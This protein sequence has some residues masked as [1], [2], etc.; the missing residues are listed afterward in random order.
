M[1][2][3]CS[4]C[5]SDEIIDELRVVDQHISKHVKDSLCIEIR[6]RPRNTFSPGDQRYALKA[7]VCI[8]CGTT[9]LYVDNPQSLKDSYETYLKNI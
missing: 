5:G 2:K 4:Q 7:A 8:S 9:R 6:T 3:E 1:K